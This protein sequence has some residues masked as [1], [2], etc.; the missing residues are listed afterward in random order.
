MV[1]GFLLRTIAGHSVIH[2]TSGRVDGIHLRSGSGLGDVTVFYGIPYAEAPVGKNRFRVSK[3]ITVP[4]RQRN[5]DTKVNTGGSVPPPACPQFPRLPKLSDPTLP[6]GGLRTDEDCLKLSIYVPSDVKYNG[7]NSS[8]SSWEYEKLPILVIIP[9]DGF[10]FADS[11]VYDGTRLA[12]MDHIIVITLNYR[13]GKFLLI[14]SSISFLFPAPMLYSV[15]TPHYP[16]Y[17]WFRCLRIP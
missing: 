5:S 6:R 7:T 9:G 12:A 13:V 8:S 3:G 4:L 2:T 11:G 14:L 10:N 1:A 17:V 15:L 16:Y